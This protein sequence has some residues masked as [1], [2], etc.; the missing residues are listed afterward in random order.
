MKC[1]GLDVA[2]LVILFQKMVKKSPK[3]HKLFMFF[4]K[5]KIS[6]FFAPIAN[7]RHKKTLLEIC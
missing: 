6:I 5:K 1:L 2:S 7:F 3:T 4:F